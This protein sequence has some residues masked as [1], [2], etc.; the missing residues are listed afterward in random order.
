MRMWLVN[1][2]KMCRQH[3]LGEHSELHMFAGLM[4]LKKGVAGFIANNL[5]EPKS[6]KKRHY[7]LAREMKRRGYLHRSRLNFSQKRI[8]YLD[9]TIQ[10][11]RMDRKLSQKQLLSRCRRC[12]ALFKRP[13]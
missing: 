6:L 13:I 5:L 11:Y 2:K 1:P 8:S 9:K 10:N 3:L 12:R 4:R 7:E